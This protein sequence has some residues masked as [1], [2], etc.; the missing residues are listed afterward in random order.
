MPPSIAVIRCS[1]IW[2]S[3]V[4]PLIFD[5]KN[6]KLRTPEDGTPIHGVV[7]TFGGLEMDIE[8]FCNTERK[9]MEELISELELKYPDIKAKVIGAMERG[10]IN[11]WQ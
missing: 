1:V 4:F 7:A 11:G 10:N 9:A 2:E 8:A 5:F 3:P 6:A